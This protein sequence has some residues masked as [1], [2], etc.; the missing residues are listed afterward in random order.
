MRAHLRL[1][2]PDGQVLGAKPKYAFAGG[3]LVRWLPKAKGSTRKEFGF[4]KVSKDW[5]WYDIGEFDLAELQKIPRP[6]M[7]GL[8]LFIQD[9]GVEFDK[10]EI[11]RIDK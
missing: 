3:L 11:S 1:K 7:D 9:P 10:I 2:E 4:D 8:C 5:S 6:V